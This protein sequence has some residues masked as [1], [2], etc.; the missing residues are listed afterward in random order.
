MSAPVSFSHIGITVPD[1]DKAVEFYIKALGLYQIMAPTTIKHDASAIGQMCDD[2]FGEGWGSFRIAHLS[3]SDGV[4][5]ELFEF[6]QT[7]PDGSF[8]ILAAEALSFL[9]SGSRPRRQDQADRTIWRTA[10]DEAGAPL[11]SRRKALSHGL[12]RGSVRQYCGT[13]QPFL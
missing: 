10:A 11:L 8:R 2:V 9:R 5:V 6:P 12:L 3:T 13:V 1:L 7:Q 4:G